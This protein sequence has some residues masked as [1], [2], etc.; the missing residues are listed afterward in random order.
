ME[1]DSAAVYVRVPFVERTLSG[2]RRLVQAVGADAA[3]QLSGS[4]PLIWDL[5]DEHPEVPQ[6]VAMLQQQ[7]SD[8]PETITQGVELALDSLLD[9]ELV[10]RQ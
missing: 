8:P 5:L 4:A 10:R 1:S 2:G 6:L 7:F 9:A 3:T